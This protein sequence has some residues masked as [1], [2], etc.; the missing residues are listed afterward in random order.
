MKNKKIIKKILFIFLIMTIIIGILVINTFERKTLMISN[1]TPSVKNKASATIYGETVEGV[2]KGGTLSDFLKKV[3]TGTMFFDRSKADTTIVG[4]NGYTLETNGNSNIVKRNL[5]TENTETALS[6]VVYL[7]P[8][9]NG[10]PAKTSGFVTNTGIDKNATAD[11]RSK[12]TMKFKDVITMQ[13][14]SK[15]DIAITISNIYII[16]QRSDTVRYT[17]LW[18]GS[19]ISIQGPSDDINNNLAYESGCGLAMHCDISI[20]VLNDDGTHLSG[21]KI[22]FEVTDLDVSDKTRIGSENYKPKADDPAYNQNLTDEEKL[23][24]YNNDYRESLYILKGALTDAYMPASNWLEV[25]RL[26]DGNFANGLRF[27]AYEKGDSATLNTGFMTLIDSK[28][29]TF[30]WYGSSTTDGVGTVL[31][32]NSANHKIKATSSTGGKIS[33]YITENNIIANSD[34]YTTRSYIHCFADG[35]DV[36]YKMEAN[37]NYDLGSITIDNVKFAPSDFSSV[38]AGKS[39]QSVTVKKGETN[40]KFTVT[41]DSTG[42]ITNVVYTFADNNANHEIS[43]TWNTIPASLIVKYLEKGT[44]KELATNVKK[45]GVVGEAYD[46]NSEKKTIAN[47]T[48]VEDSGNTKGTYTTASSTTPIEVIYYYKLNDY[49]YKVEYYYDGKID[50]TKTE[51]S[52]SGYGSKVTKYTDKVIPGYKFDKTE[53]LPLTI[54]NDPS[55]NII[56]VYYVKR[57][58]LGYTVNYLEKDTNKTIHEPKVVDKTEFNSVIQ[59]KDEIIEIEKYKYENSDKEKI[60][61][62]EKDE[63]NVINLYYSKKTGSVIVKYIDEDT[64]KEIEKSDTIN[65]NVDDD[66]ISKSKNI[67]GYDLVKNSGNTTGKI[68]EEGTTVIYYYKA[69]AKEVT[70]AKQEVTKLPK[71]GNVSGFSIIIAI[72]ATLGILFAIGYHKLKDIK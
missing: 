38:A 37:K 72:V 46:V 43:V 39:N 7:G 22:L 56:K 66:Y 42:R 60:T 6:Q 34:N 12:F 64:N 25:K 67:D 54:S 8:N 63:D 68:T 62:S 20:S 35:T 14:T 11:T 36:N 45:T 15:K 13:D 31:F 27:S 19:G 10:I 49:E 69:K 52:K 71:T 47:Y 1:V 5:N 32:T 70:P 28:E 55:K 30:R 58:D 61:I 59:A 50:N 51:T 17:G 48:F 3:P 23:K 44:G 9:G 2:N 29:T 40:Y 24:L 33:N 65:G 18:R 21:G 57:T 16:N 26:S 41:K 53:K 4:A